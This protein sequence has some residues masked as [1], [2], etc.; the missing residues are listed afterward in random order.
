M[1]SL[2]EPVAAY[3]LHTRPYRET[4]AL[5]DFFT[6]EHGK[7]SAVV[8]GLRR[9]GSKQRAVIQPF[10]PLQIRWRGRQDLKSLISAEAVG[11]NGILMGNSLMCGLYVN[12]LL[13]RLLMPFDGVPRLY[14]FYQYVITALVQQQDVEGALRTFERQILQE[15]GYALDYSQLMT[16]QIY[17]FDPDEWCFTPVTHITESERIRYFSGQDLLH[18]EED[19]YEHPSA[20][21]AAKRLMRLAIDHLTKDRP[22]QSRSLF[23]KRS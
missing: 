6:L 5:V 4:S 15:T 13:Q 20:R 19:A 17:R 12:E 11:H 23:L 1:V 18:I 2:D 16:D 21:K 7:V 22:L 10:V 9:P 8:K 3:V 14:V